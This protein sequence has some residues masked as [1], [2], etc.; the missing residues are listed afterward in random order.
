MPL[1]KLAS[2]RT[3]RAATAALLVLASAAGADAQIF[4]CVDSSGHTTYQQSACPLD[5]TGG[6]IELTDDV[7][8]ARESNPIDAAWQA[9][10]R[11]KN[12]SVGMP[13]RYVRIALGPPRD[14]RPGR[15]NEDASEVWS[16]Q[17]DTQTLRIGFRN[18]T[19]VWT[20]QDSP[21]GASGPAPDD[22][23]MQRVLRR[24]NVSEGLACDDVVAALGP[25]QEIERRGAQR[26]VLRYVWE[27]V[28]GD[29]YARTIVSCTSGRVSSVERVTT[30]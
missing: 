26:D 4:K 9:A 20:R 10:A 19:V 25:P 28:S 17:K 3:G 21:D 22:D 7:A 8:A 24:R 23:A 30:R 5:A 6:R 11:D 15:P 18:D 27:P 29:P 12:V 13:R 1:A 14:A 16:Y 2:G